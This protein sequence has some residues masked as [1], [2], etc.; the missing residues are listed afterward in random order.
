[1]NVYKLNFIY[2]FKEKFIYYSSS[3]LS[4]NK[5]YLLRIFIWNFD[6]NYKIKF[7]Y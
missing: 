5:V 7:K 3:L 1:M 4:L 6:V 2:I